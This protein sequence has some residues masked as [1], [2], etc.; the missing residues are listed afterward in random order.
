MRK[1]ISQDLEHPEPQPSFQRNSDVLSW[2][3]AKLTH[4]IAEN[5]N[6]EG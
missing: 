6:E 3:L 1:H 4:I 2:H 5:L